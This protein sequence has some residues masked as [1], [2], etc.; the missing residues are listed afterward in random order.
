[1]G[2]AAH[3]EGG[4]ATGP[5][6]AGRA[7]AQRRTRRSVRR[8]DVPEGLN[9]PFVNRHSLECA[10]PPSKTRQSV[11]ALHSSG[12]R[13]RFC[14]IS[15]ASARRRCGRFFAVFLL[16]RPSE[17]EI[18]R[19]VH[20]QKRSTLSYGPVGLSRGSPSGYGIDE[21]RLM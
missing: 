10:C 3:G 4:E 18:S 13:A 20:Q 6:C 17:T 19:F 2:V 15:P 1:D 21:Q 9:L 11:R 12:S 7:A 16:K 5:G 14:R 8:D